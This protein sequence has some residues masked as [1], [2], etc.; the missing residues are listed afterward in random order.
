[1]KMQV[2]LPHLDPN[3]LLACVYFVLAVSRGCQPRYACIDNISTGTVGDCHGKGVR[4]SALVYDRHAGSCHAVQT[5]LRRP[6]S[7]HND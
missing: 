7:S 6:P 3:P 5:Q 2:G 1:M 4:V